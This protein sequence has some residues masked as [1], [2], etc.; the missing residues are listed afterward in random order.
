MQ[1]LFHKAIDAETLVERDPAE[2]D[3]CRR[4]GG[5][6]WLDIVHPTDNDIE[7]LERRFGFDRLSIDDVVD[8]TLLPKLDDYGDYAFVVLHGV[9]TGEGT[10][11]ST[12]ELDVFIGVDFLVTVH[13]DR[14]VGIDWVAEH[15]TTSVR[16]AEGGPAWAAAAIAEAG[17][18]RYLPLL[19]ALEDR[20]D[21]LE[22]RAVTADATVIGDS[23]ALRR[24][25]VVLRRIIGPQRDV[26]RQLATL[27]PPVVG[28]RAQ[29][30]FGDVYDH[31]FRLAESLD[32]A[33]F[34]LSAVLETYRGAIA[35][36]TNEVMKVLT[37]FSAI[38]LPLSLIAGIY[39]MNVDNLPGAAT[40]WGFTALVGAMLAIGA[41]LWLYFSRRGFIGGPR[42][43]DIPR[44]V[45]LGLVQ[46][47][48]AP[49]RLVTS[50]IAGRIGGQ[51]G[52]T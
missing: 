18:R 1:R 3:A 21:D 30:A 40:P 49:L 9:V 33:R 10:R 46:V 16:I 4:A 47:G 23:Q 17:S 42:I 41:M 52:E 32:A 25:V 11:L 26:M 29:R 19:D 43:R 5:W 48:T 15:A 28:S 50:R 22:S 6:L 20:I 37:V 2:L 39:G 34:L 45:G 14:V 24:D 8:T 35:E 44:S 12:T 13:L 27:P 38:V 7:V 51:D 36:R 31:H